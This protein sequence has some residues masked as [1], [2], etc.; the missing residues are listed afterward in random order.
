GRRTEPSRRRRLGRRPRVGDVP[1]RR[2]RHGRGAT[3][4]APPGAG[5]RPRR[6]S[7]RGLS[8]GARASVRPARGA[9]PSP[10]GA[11]GA[12]RRGGASLMDSRRD[13]ARAAALA[14]L[15]SIALHAGLAL[16]LPRLG[17]GPAR[18]P[19]A[20]LPPLYVDLIEPLVAV[21]GRSG[22]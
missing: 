15:L 4:T 2:L 8:R 5:A 13:V 16:A 11:P 21:D 18:P 19:T 1:A 12:G 20:A 3:G 6:R 7:A 14:L 22:A 17:I 9:L 10:P